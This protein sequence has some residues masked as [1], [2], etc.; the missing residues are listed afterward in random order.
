MFDNK[1][2]FVLNGMIFAVLKKV[3]YLNV[4]IVALSKFIIVASCARKSFPLGEEQDAKKK[5]VIRNRQINV[6]F[7]ISKSEYRCCLNAE[8]FLHCN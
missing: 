5:Y 3:E 1:T 7:F 8:S 6:F 2:S 4:S